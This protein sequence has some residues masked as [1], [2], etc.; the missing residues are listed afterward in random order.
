MDLEFNIQGFYCQTAFKYMSNFP[1]WGWLWSPTTVS[2]IILS[3]SSNI[4][5]SKHFQESDKF[6]G[7]LNWAESPV[8]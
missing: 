3:S 6:Q 1:D 5:Q 2:F 8:H 7:T 4:R